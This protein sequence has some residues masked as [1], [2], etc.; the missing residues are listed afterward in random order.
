[1]NDCLVVQESGSLLVAA[2]D[3]VLQKDR[4]QLLDDLRSFRVAKP[5]NAVLSRSALPK[6][7]QD[8]ADFLVGSHHRPGHHYDGSK[9]S[10]A[11]LPASIMKFKRGEREVRL[12]L[13][14]RP[15]ND[16]RQRLAQQ[17]AKLEPG[18]R[19]TTLPAWLQ[20]R[21]GN[22]LQALYF[23]SN[24][25]MV[26]EKRL[27]LT[28]ALLEKLA[29]ISSEWT[30]DYERAKADCVAELSAARGWSSPGGQPQD[31]FGS[32]PSQTQELLLA[33]AQ[34]NFKEWGF[35]TETEAFEF[36][37]SSVIVRNELALQIFVAFEGQAP[38]VTSI[39]LP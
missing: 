26:R 32:L 37:Q 16:D 24:R 21:D 31:P 10:V 39:V 8:V 2:P 33:E 23:A 19:Q 25:A 3:L 9:M 13:T 1:M 22:Q 36:L 5:E 6:S 15:T 17:A 27:A 20:L 28:A 11:V 35:A 7:L 18:E 34:G 30:K 14:N 38:G 12:T 29:A 4:A